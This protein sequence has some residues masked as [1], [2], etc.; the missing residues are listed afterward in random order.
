MTRQCI[1]PKIPKN[2]EW[3]KEKM[4][5]AQAL[6]VGVVLDEEHMTF[7]ADDGLTITGQDTQELTTTAIFQTDDLDAFDSDYDEA[8]STN[9]DL[10][11][12]LSVDDSDVLSESD[13]DITSDNNVISYDQYLKENEN[14]IVNESLT[15]EL[16][17]YKEQ[18][19]FFRERQKF[20]LTDIE[21]YIDGQIR[22]V[23]VD[24]NAKF[25]SYQKEIQT[26]K[27][28][29][30]AN[31][32][33]NKV[34]NNQMDILKQE[35]YEKQ[36][37]YIE[38]IVDLEKKKKALDNIVYKTGQTVKTMH[39]L[40][41]PQ[42]FYDESHKIA[43]GYQNPLYMTHAQR[44]QPSLYYGHTIVRKHDALFV[45]NT[46]ETLKLAKES[47]LKMNVKQNDPIAKEKKGILHPLVMLH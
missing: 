1:K 25:D 44:K 10:M 34:L 47:K 23:V 31:I 26:L 28:Q 7:L 38:E 46:E 41:K 24:R 5:F 33:S 8:P 20:D 3:F 37:K 13:I 6:E 4:M 22:G 2:L 45:I 35:F 43:L 15:A 36:D 12:K 30:S 14:E 18:I 19:K 42:V 40:T 16:E 9:A 17:R 27:L 21:K 32:V 39:M 29:L 11:T